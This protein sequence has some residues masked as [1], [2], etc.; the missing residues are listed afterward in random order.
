MGPVSDDTFKRHYYRKKRE[1]NIEQPQ[2]E[3]KKEF[4]NYKT[5]HPL[6]EPMFLIQI[7]REMNFSRA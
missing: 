3:K 7:K 2:I 1:Q 5:Y 4:Q 6:L